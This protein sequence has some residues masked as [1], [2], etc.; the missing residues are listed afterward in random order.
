M[1]HKIDAPPTETLKFYKS[2]SSTVKENREFGAQAFPTL[3]EEMR[4]RRSY[5]APREGEAKKVLE[6]AKKVTE[7][8]TYYQG[9]AAMLW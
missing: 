8:G 2:F 3:E 1:N 9:T 4:G 5:A 7:E 6:A